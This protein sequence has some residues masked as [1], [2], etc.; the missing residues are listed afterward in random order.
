MPRVAGFVAS[1][2]WRLHVRVGLAAASRRPLAVSRLAGPRLACLSTGPDGG[3][4]ADFLEKAARA[5]LKGGENQ[6]EAARPSGLDDPPRRRTAGDAHSA[7]LATAASQGADMT[8]NAGNPPG[9]TDDEIRTFILESWD[10]PKGG[11]ALRKLYKLQRALD[12]HGLWPLKVNTFDA[13]LEAKRLVQSAVLR[14]VAKGGVPEL[15]EVAG[16][17]LGPEDAWPYERR[18][19]SLKSLARLRLDDIKAEQPAQSPKEPQRRIGHRPGGYGRQ[20]GSGRPDH[21]EQ[22]DGGQAG[23]W[24]ARDRVTHDSDRYG[25]AWDDDDDDDGCRGA[26]TQRRH[27]RPRSRSRR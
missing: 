12:V 25:G 23:G 2:S 8:P 24:R 18:V 9:L 1:A 17:D 7:V 19:R 10:A 5:G 26:S 27:H 15:S 16:E 22:R 3:S 21:G 20:G 13:R 4:A 14:I 6:S 11:T